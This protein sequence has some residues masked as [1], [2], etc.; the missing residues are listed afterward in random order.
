MIGGAT[1]AEALEVSKLNAA[2]PGVRLLL[3]GTTIH[4]SESFLREVQDSVSHWQS[5]GK[6]ELITKIE[7]GVQKSGKVSF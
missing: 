4:N 2:N 1:F 5:S 3:G 6:E 7:T